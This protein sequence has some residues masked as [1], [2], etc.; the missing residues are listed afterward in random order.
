M[1]ESGP[2]QAVDLREYLGILRHRK[3]TVVLATALV[4]G[5]AL[6]FSLRQTPIY[7][8]ET[9]VLVRPSTSSPGFA[10]PLVN[11]ETERALVDSAIVATIARDDLNLQQSPGSLLDDLDVSVE[12]NTEILAIRYSD[13]DPLRA[14]SLASAFAQAYISFRLEQAQ[15]QF[16]AQSAGIQKRIDD[17]EDRLA[18]LEGQIDAATSPARQ[19]ELA[20]ER[21]SLIARLGVLQQELENLRTAAEVQGGGGEIVQ[22][23][24]LPSAPSSPNHVRSGALALAVGVALGVGVAFLRERLDQR[25]RGR[26]DL[27][28]QLAAPVLATVPKVKGWSK[29][30]RTELVSASDPRSGPA[31]AYRT[32]RTNLQFIARG[33]DFRILSVTSPSLGEGKTTSVANLAVALAQTGKKVIAVSCDLRKPRLHRFFDLENTKGVTTTLVGETS[34]HLAIQRPGLDSLRVLA[35]GPVPPNPAELLAS[36]EMDELLESLRAS[37]DFVIIDT[38]PLLAVAD[39]LVLAPKSDGVIIIADSGT[40]TRGAVAHTREQLQQVGAKIVGGV[41][42]NFDPQRGKYYAN[43]YG[44]DNSYR[45]KDDRPVE[46]PSGNG[47]QRVASPIDM[48]Q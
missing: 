16:E 18:A 1:Q 33:G 24:D 39:A 34:L 15:E 4:V 10:P 31:E 9:R 41:L 42:N 8:S 35:S 2:P 37:A 40:T 44:Y 29:S 45:Y 17:S 27:E 19:N 20:A 3:W 38:P 7:V 21:D 22:P 14:Q 46:P 12:A 26:P 23:A 11:L 30:S 43:Y 32:L 47:S 6:A 48:W 28:E 36:E 5:S 13:P 25:L